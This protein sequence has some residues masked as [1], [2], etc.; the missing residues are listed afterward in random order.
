MTEEFLKGDPEREAIRNGTKVFDRESARAIYKKLDFLP[1][2]STGYAPCL[3]GK[4]C[5]MA[6]YHHLKA[7]GILA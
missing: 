1:S 3:C 4:R 7:K 2:R 6:C 5:D